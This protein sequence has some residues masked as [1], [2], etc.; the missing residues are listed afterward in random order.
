MTEGAQDRAGRKP[1]LFARLWP[2]IPLLVVY[3]ALAALYTW[4]ASRRLVPTIF[5][6]EIEMAQLSRAI[7]ETG[8]PARRGEPYA[9]AS[10]LAY[11]LAPAWWLAS[12]SAAYAAA[13]LVLVLSMTAAVFPAFAL[14]R[15]VVPYW[16]AVGAAGAAIAVPALAYSPFL[17]EE[18]LAYPLSTLALW[19][20]ARCLAEP[21]WMRLGVAVVSSTVAALTRTQLAALFAVL[22]LGL[23]W[24]GWQSEPVRRWRSEWSRWDWAGAITLTVGCALAFSAAM[25]SRSRSWRETTGYFKDRILEHAS[26]ATGAL[27]IGIGILPMLLGIAALARPRDEPRDPRTRALVTTAVA[28]LAVFVGY[29]GIKGAFLSTTFGTVVVERNLIYLYPLL[30]AAA[31]MAVHRG[32]GRAWAIAVA[33]VAVLYVVVATPVQLDYPYYEAHG[34]AILT[35]A[36]RELGW[37]SGRI[38]VA[39]VVS[40]LAAL[41]VVIALRL[42]RT[43]SAAFRVVA[44]SSAAVVVAWGLTAQVYAA[45]SERSLSDQAAGNL[46]RPFDWVDRAT[47][48]EPVVVIG[49]QITD[50][51]G[52]WLTEFFNR[53]VRKVWSLDG[54]ALRAGAPV[55]TPDLASPD[56]TLTP[57]PGTEYAL[58]LNGVELDAPL[59]ARRGNDKLHRIGGQALKLRAALTGV[60]SDGWMTVSRTSDE[61]VARAAYTRYDVSGDGPGFAL[62]KL[63]RVEWCPSPGKRTPGRATV[64]IGP[65]AIGSDKQPAIG[66]VTAERTAIVRDCRVTGFLLPAPNEPWRVEIE[67]EPTFV[68]NEIDPSVSDTRKL[69]AVVSAEFRPL[70]DD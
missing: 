47:G 46:A 3:F 67:L 63:S 30:F 43:D 11:V 18:P 53:S 15:L 70:F 64:R 22:A 14:A 59:V 48:E 5:I 27:A 56:G 10:L 57:S 41:G 55:L 36:N 21:G 51:T 33:A 68:P 25:G 61:T 65:V 35:F 26:W 6:D 19:L 17:V 24:I 20:I 37:P 13:K 44:A 45:E 31:A 1:D 54:S 29:A 69:G 7:S 52:I 16:Y 50:P 38:E 4:Q 34:F 58:A 40:F 32:V 49:Q 42:L 2:A 8:G 39:L 60:E 9:G 23:L 62:V 66:R 12:T 28:S